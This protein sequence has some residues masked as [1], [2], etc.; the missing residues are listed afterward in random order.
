[1]YDMSVTELVFHLEMFSLNVRMS[2]NKSCML[3][4]SDVSHV[5]MSPC[6]LR[7]E[8]HANIAVRSSVKSFGL[9]PQNTFL[10]LQKIH[11][12]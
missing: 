11:A 2:R 3:V 4:I 5:E 6:V 12:F 8:G 7:L 10:N 9:N 1:M